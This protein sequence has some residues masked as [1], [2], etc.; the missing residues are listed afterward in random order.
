MNDVIYNHHI[1]ELLMEE[2]SIVNHQ[3]YTANEIIFN[4]YG[5]MVFNGEV[6]SIKKRNKIVHNLPNIYK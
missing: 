6:V 2:P 1:K 4:T 5:L 3:R